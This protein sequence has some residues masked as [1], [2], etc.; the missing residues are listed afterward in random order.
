MYVLGVAGWTDRGHDASATLV[1][2][3]KIVAAAEEERFTRR[4]HAFDVLP[5]NAIRF[6]LEEEGINIDDIGDVGMYWD[7]PAHYKIRGIRRD[8]SKITEELFPRKLF[9]YSDPPEI[10]FLGHHLSHASSA[11]RASGFDRSAILVVDGAG[12]DA[13]TTIW[14]GSGKSL[15]VVR[16]FGIPD[17]IGYFYEGITHYVGLEP[18]EPGKTMGLASYGKSSA[19]IDR[20]FELTKYGYRLKVPEG[21][22]VLGLNGIS[23]EQAQL[24]DHWI[25]EF[26]SMFGPGNE[27][28]HTYKRLSGGYRPDPTMSEIYMRAAA[29]AQNAL[30]KL[31]VHL[32]ETAVRE[33][34]SKNLCI[35]GG[36]GLNCVANG[37]ILRSGL[38]DNIFI[39]P[40]ANDAGG[41]MG[42]ALELSSRLG[43]T[44]NLE[45]RHTYLGP[46]FSMDEI[47]SE[48]NRLKIPFEYHNNI[49]DDVAGLLAEGNVVGWFQ[50]RMEWGPRALG[51]RSILADPRDPKMKDKINNYVKF[52]EWFRPFAPSILE[53]NAG[54]YLV[55]SRPSPFMLLS[56]DV[57]KE[58]RDEI[59]AVV[60]VDGTTRPQTVDRRTNPRYYKLISRFRELTGVPMVLNTSFNVRGEP[61][62]LTP[63]DAIRTFYSTGMDYLAMGDFLIRK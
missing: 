53:E 40:A 30:E 33:T 29:S 26:T 37:K 11:F 46:E 49:E 62:V 21:R 24:R 51:S 38:I 42:A 41:S 34:G 43:R 17:S 15:D 55:D 7:L 16:R 57:Y 18:S 63:Y 9:D 12:E 14:Y 52:R 25:N 20:L 31:M 27:K 2:D 36:I 13:S 19:D 44:P 4:K 3:G 48:L 56:F 35:A 6:C 23:D 39:Q 22:V 32:T 45:L 10:V 1:K 54:E 5:H 60:H 59:P 8:F 28:I 61:I 50:G 58:K 47:E